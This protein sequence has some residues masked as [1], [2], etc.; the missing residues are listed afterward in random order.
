MDAKAEET[1]CDLQAQVS[2]L[3]VAMRALAR[4]HPAPEA[5]LES[6]KQALAELGAAPPPIPSYA[7][8]SESL[9][10]RCQAYAEDWTAELVELAVPRDIE[11]PPGSVRP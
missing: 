9:A 6:W 1:L 8:R 2:V 5:S 7:R 4:S 10:E 11:P 3:R